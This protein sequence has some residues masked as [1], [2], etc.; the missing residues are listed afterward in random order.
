MWQSS[1]QRTSFTIAALELSAA[2]ENPRIPSLDAVELA[3]YTSL[4]NMILNL[5][6]TVCK[7]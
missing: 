6:E 1:L 4:A 7:G 2:G 3:A 5:D